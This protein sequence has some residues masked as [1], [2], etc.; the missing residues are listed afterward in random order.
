MLILIRRSIFKISFM[1]RWRQRLIDGL[2]EDAL[3][4]VSRA[5]TIQ[6]NQDLKNFED[7]LKK[8]DKALETTK[9]TVIR[10]HER[11]LMERERDYQKKESQLQED[12]A[13][14]T[15]HKEILEDAIRANVLLE[16]K[17]RE[18][19]NKLNT[20]HAHVKQLI[21]LTERTIRTIR[22]VEESLEESVIQ[23]DEIDRVDRMNKQAILGSKADS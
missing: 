1:N 15:L 14:I 11:L 23:Q 16:K 13:D 17:Y 6:R 18:T 5:N 22:L 20:A 9:K 7:E 19:I 8:K 21:S 10:E 12:K 4:E 2:I 3:Y